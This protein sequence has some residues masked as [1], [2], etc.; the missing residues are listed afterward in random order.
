MME[1]ED[2]EEDAVSVALRSGPPGRSAQGGFVQV[3]Q[4]KGQQ[5]QTA[6]KASSMDDYQ[7]LPGRPLGG[8]R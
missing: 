6:S 8:P 4:R 2:D 7:G 5:A 1:E 3:E